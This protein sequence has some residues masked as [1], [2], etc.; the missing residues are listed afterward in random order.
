MGAS[1]QEFMGE[2][3]TLL[4]ARTEKVKRL[5][6][7]ARTPLNNHVYSLPKCEDSGEESRTTPHTW[8][9]R[10][11]DSL[12]RMT[13]QLITLDIYVIDNHFLWPRRTDKPVSLK[14]S[15]V[16][17]RP[18]THYHLIPIKKTIGPRLKCL[19]WSSHASSQLLL[20]IVGVIKCGE[21]M[22]SHLGILYCY[23]LKTS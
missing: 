1:F 12:L 16:A 17:L 19:P 6:P 22:N 7:P 11:R 21:K 9:K 13:Q 15:S 5:P 14:G 3:H 8:L 18:L 4:Q 20:Q 23:V 2:D 10:S